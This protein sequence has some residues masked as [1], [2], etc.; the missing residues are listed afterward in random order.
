ML[1]LSSVDFLTQLYNLFITD[2][3]AVHHVPEVRELIY[4]SGV[5][6]RYLPPYSP[7]LN[8]IEEAFARVKHHLRQNDVILQ[9]AA[10]P[11]PLIWNAFSK[12]TADNC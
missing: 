7:D 1:K 4:N 10:D 12:I 11:I 2:N 3:H 6:I 9:M 8:P 5:I